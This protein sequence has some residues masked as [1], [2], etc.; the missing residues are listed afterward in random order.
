MLA[1]RSTCVAHVVWYYLSRIFYVLPWIMWLV[2]IMVT[3]SSDVTDVWQCNLVTLTLTLV[4]KIKNKKEN[5]KDNKNEKENKKKVKFTAFSFDT[6][7]I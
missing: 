7:S 1:S 2:T 6:T 5:Q 4:L 3:M